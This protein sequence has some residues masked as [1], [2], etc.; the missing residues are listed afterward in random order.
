MIL[1]GEG[2][3]PFYIGRFSCECGFEPD[4]VTGK[5]LEG[6]WRKWVGIHT[7]IVDMLDYRMQIRNRIFPKFRTWSASR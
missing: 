1:K 6:L 5:S 4:D 3:I 7:Y 2:E